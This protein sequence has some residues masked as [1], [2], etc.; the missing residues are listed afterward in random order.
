MK[1]FVLIIVCISG[2]VILKGQVHSFIQPNLNGHMK[3]LLVPLG[4]VDTNDINVV[5]RAIE[6]YY[7]AE[8]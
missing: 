6:G 3:V 8:Q 4:Q 5:Q 2:S 7:W 1:Y